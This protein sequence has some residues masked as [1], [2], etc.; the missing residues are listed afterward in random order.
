QNVESWKRNFKQ[1]MKSLNP[2]TKAY[3]K[4][5]RVQYQKERK[6]VISI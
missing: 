1:K 6:R 5:Y 3:K 2:K 4:E